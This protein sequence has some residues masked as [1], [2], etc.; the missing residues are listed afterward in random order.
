MIYSFE[1]LAKAHLPQKLLSVDEF[2]EVRK[3]WVASKRPKEEEEPAVAVTAAAE[4]A[5]EEAK[6]PKEVKEAKEPEEAASV[7]RTNYKITETGSV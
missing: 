6:E 4:D 1:L 7:V 5:T 3:E 2:L